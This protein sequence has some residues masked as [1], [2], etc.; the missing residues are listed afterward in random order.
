MAK[1]IRRLNPNLETPSSGKIDAFSGQ[2]DPI[3]G[4]LA[5]ASPQIDTEDQG[6]VS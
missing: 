4:F 3:S 2:I 6:L 1:A 5:T